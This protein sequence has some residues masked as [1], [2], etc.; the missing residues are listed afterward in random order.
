MIFDNSNRGVLF[1]NRDH[2]QETDPNYRGT[3]NVRP[4]KK[5]AGASVCLAAE[6]ATIRK[7]LW[8]RARKIASE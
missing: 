7:R 4:G 8:D 3:I 6:E 2:A 5:L 1:K